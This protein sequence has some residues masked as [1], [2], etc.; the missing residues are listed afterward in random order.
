M[1]AELNSGAVARQPS[2][3]RSRERFEKVIAAADQLLA[4][5]GL[6][7]FSIPA[8]A[9]TLGFTRR[10]IYLFF[11]TPY[12][13]IN[14]VTRRYI[15]KLEAHLRQRAVSLRDTDV[16]ELVARMTYSAA[17]FH[18][19]NP[20]ARLLILGGAV[21][22]LSYRSQEHNT[23]HLGQIARQ[24][25][26]GFGF[27]IPPSPPDIPTVAIEIGTACFRLSYA[28][29]GQITNAYKVESA[30]V[31]LMYLRD[32]LGMKSTLTREHLASFLSS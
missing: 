26:Q 17:D 25:M 20:V 1:Y 21:T 28:N 2:Q 18:N 16:P 3:E 31:M 32:S 27:D 29:H 5:E 19:Q 23:R 14:E 15:E 6:S 12:A 13:V 4:E 11:P 7:G 30:F 9:E 8:L 24:I 22:D 10:S